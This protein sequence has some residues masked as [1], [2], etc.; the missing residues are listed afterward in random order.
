LGDNIEVTGIGAVGIADRPIV[1]PTTFSVNVAN[2]FAVRARGG[3]RFVTATDGSGNPTKTTT[4]T[5]TGIITLNDNTSRD[6]QLTELR[7]V[8]YGSVQTL[9]SP[10]QSQARSNIGV[11][12]IAVQDAN[13]VNIT[14]GN[15]SGITDLAIA[16]G[17]TG[18]STVD[19]ARANLGFS[20]QFIMPVFRSHSTMTF[21]TT[22]VVGTGSATTPLNGMFDL[23]AGATPN[24]Q[25]RYRVNSDGTSINNRTMG[26]AN[27][28]RRVEI[29]GQINFVLAPIGM[30]NYFIFGKT[31]GA[32]FGKVAAGDYVGVS[33]VNDS[34][35]EGFVC[36]AGGVSSVLF[37]PV[38]R[39][40]SLGLNW[41]I[42]SENGTV[43][44]Y[45]NGVL[46]GATTD[47]P[48]S[49]NATGTYNIELEST[50]ANSIMQCFTQS[51]GY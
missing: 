27:W 6:L 15:I 47:G 4:V 16:D 9:T 8:N 17:G 37:T 34:L 5:P 46:V 24:S 22:D 3:V 1:A 13:N 48:V 10:Q 19:G 51:Q 20:S 50:V 21:S 23:R 35:T 7:A 2:E 38:A 26:F 29:S 28:T 36:K 11:G 40:G 12:T 43:S 45:A 31:A 25:V 14:G 39:D 30:T 41:L 33:F 32:G 44:F 49:T 18:A 42:R